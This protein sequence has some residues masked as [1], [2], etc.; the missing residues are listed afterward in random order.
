MSELNGKRVAFIATDG[1]EDAELTSPWEA[2]TSAGATAVLV[3]PSTGEIT[4]AKGHA[5]K[6]DLAVGEASVDDFDALVIPGGVKN[7]DDIRVDPSAVAFAKAF[8]AE[9]KPVGVI[10]HGPWL[11]IEA[12]VVDGRTLTSWPSLRTDLKNAGAEWVDREVVVDAGLVSS[13]NPGD[14]PAFTAKLVE[15]IGEGEHD[16]QHA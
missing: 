11:L 12:G 13:R 4:G 2:V 3:S 14:L 5:Q 10:C 16:R 8:F 9:H 6:V 1:F 15:E 7:A